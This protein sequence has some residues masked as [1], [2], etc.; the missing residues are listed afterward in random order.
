[1]VSGSLGNELLAD[2]SGCAHQAFTNLVWVERVQALHLY[3]ARDL[4]SALVKC[5]T[6]FNY[7]VFYLFFSIQYLPDLSTINPSR[8][9]YLFLLQL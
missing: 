9:F 3:L 2:E 7:L 5:Y 8:R 4:P 6:V 1:M